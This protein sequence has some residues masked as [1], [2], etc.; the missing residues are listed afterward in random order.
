VYRAAGKDDERKAFQKAA[1]ATTNDYSDTTP[2]VNIYS[3][4]Q[5]EAIN[6]TGAVVGR[7]GIS[8]VYAESWGP[9]SDWSTVKR[10]ETSTRQVEVRTQYRTLEVIGEELCWSDWG[11]WSE[12]VASEPNNGKYNPDYVQVETK[13]GTFVE[14]RYEY[15]R[16]AYYDTSTGTVRYAASECTTNGEWHSLLVSYQMPRV[17]HG[18]AYRDGELWYNET[19]YD[20]TTV[21]WTY[22]R[23]R[24]RSSWP[25]PV[26]GN[27][28]EWG[29]TRPNQTDTNKVEERIVYRYRD[30]K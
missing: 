10:T 23:F 29:F 4:Y 2:Y 22:Y 28:S 7:S 8:Y 19:L 15:T 18:Y 20:S 16:W 27:P 26:Y 24:T 3:S 25:E 17:G 12:W 14:N 13:E 6:S 30:K 5:I 9:W 21:P 1:V 11:A